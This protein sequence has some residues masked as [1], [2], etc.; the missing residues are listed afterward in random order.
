MDNGLNG[1]ENSGQFGF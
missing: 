1:I